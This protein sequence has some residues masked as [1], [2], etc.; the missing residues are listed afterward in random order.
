MDK[1]T[2]MNAKE[3][4]GVEFLAALCGQMGKHCDRLKPRLQSIPNG[5]RQY[6]M[7]QTA[8]HRLLEDLYETMTVKGLLRIKNMMHY[9]EVKISISPIERNALGY[10]VVHEKDM[11]VLT[12]AALQNECAMCIKDGEEAKRCDLRKALWEIIP[13]E[14]IPKY[15][16][17][18]RENAMQGCLTEAEMAQREWE[19]KMKEGTNH[20]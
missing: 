15:G 3:L 4:Q 6:R 11:A 16:C 1:R 10:L 19:K 18:F 8:L 14:T 5:W 12:T 17:P 13:P 7:I 2:D 20:A 9:G